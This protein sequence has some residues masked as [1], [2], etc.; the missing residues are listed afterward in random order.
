MSTYLLLDCAPSSTFF[1]PYF[2]NFSVNSVLLDTNFLQTLPLA[3]GE[4]KHPLTLFS[5]SCSSYFSFFLLFSKHVSKSQHS[6]SPL[7]HL[8]FLPPL[9]ALLFTHQ[10]APFCPALVGFHVTVKIGDLFLLPHTLCS[11]DVHHT[12]FSCFS[13]NRS[14]HSFLAL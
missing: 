8:S 1:S 5:L 14:D 12:A 7:P 4:M 6:L 9:L 10:L 2:H 13:T 11:P 3:G